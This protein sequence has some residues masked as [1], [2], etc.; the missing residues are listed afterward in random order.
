M[1]SLCTVV[2]WA[3]PSQPNGKI[4]GYEVQFY[5]PDEWSGAIHNKTELDI[6]HIVEEGDTPS[7]YRK[8][9]LFVRVSELHAYPHQIHFAFS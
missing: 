5:I 4:T 9:E 8:R 2:L 1:K 6:Y 3:R 7:K